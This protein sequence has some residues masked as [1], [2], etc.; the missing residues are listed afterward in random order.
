LGERHPDTAGSL[1]NL[2]GLYYAT[3]R[4]P[5]AAQMMAGVVEILEQLLG[6]EHPNTIGVKENLA[7]IQQAMQRSQNSWFSRVK[8][9]LGLG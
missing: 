1:N 7:M 9:R 3:D 4:L 6:P 2:A 8:R 5:E